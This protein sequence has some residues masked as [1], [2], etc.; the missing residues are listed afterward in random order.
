MPLAAA[1]GAPDECP[2]CGCQADS[3]YLL[4]DAV[5]RHTLF[6]GVRLETVL[7][8]DHIEQHLFEH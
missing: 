5:S 7:R 3:E 6:G 2:K 8:V 1:A 4:F